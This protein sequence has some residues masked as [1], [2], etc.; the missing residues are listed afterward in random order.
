MSSICDII[1]VLSSISGNEQAHPYRVGRFLEQEQMTASR[2]RK[3]ALTTIRDAG[4]CREDQTLLARPI[5]HTLGT[6]DRH[7]VLDTVQKK[8]EVS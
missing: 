8:F 5:A 6:A 3:L 2:N 1:S 4:A 7:A